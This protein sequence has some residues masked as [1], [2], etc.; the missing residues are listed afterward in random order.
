MTLPEPDFRGKRVTVM[1]LGLFGGGAGAARYMANRGAVVTVT[2]AKSA[3]ALAPSIKELLGLPITYVL[4][5]HR[6]DDF[7][8]ADIL[9]VNPAV[10]P[11]DP[12]VRMAEKA[13]V[14]VTWEINL[15]FQIAR[16]RRLFIIG[17]TGSVGKSTTTALLGELV[18]AANPAALVGG[19]IGGSLLEAAEAAPFGTPCVVELSSFQLHTLG[20]QGVSPRVAAVTNIAPNHIDWHGSF[21]AYRRDKQNIF[22][23]QTSDDAIVL[24]YD[25]ARVAAWR[26]NASGAVILTSIQGPVRARCDAAV[27][28]HDGAFMVRDGNGTRR[29]AGRDDLPLPGDHNAA[30]A[31]LAI[32]AALRVPGAVDRACGVFRSF[33]GLPH[34]LQYVGQAEG[35]RYFNDSKATTPESAIIALKAF[36]GPVAIL[37]GGYDKG[38]SYMELAREVV[39]RAKLAVCLGAT[40]P[41]IAKHIEVC[42]RAGLGQC[43]LAMA[44]GIDDAVSVAAK[45]IPAGGVVLLSPAC[46]S[47]DMF[48]NYEARGDAFRALVA[49]LPGYSDE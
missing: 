40:G 1:G 31:L 21:R 20:K 36:D 46:A 8:N 47:W 29:I 4:G 49:R 2:D 43:E 19:N 33:R 25:D 6:D 18:R 17:V 41:L 12:Y 30:N 39:Q 9:V 48:T 45:R 15:F 28:L 35:V 27:Y 24:N 38:A 42:I 13:G 7:R 3:E 14:S 34:R 11:E 32:G 22:R 5:R 37:L 16:R 10:K 44:S 23:F 26:K